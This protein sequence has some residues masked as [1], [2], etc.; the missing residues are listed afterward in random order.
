MQ[1]PVFFISHVFSKF[2]PGVISVLSGTLMSATNAALSQ[3]SD[4]ACACG[5]LVAVDVGEGVGVFVTCGVEV[6]AE[7]GTAV[8]LGRLGG[9][10]AVACGVAVFIAA[11]WVSSA[12]TVMAAVV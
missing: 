11:A 3:N 6:S 12:T 1:V 2:C 4:V 8:L 10:V 5:V 9:A 7:V